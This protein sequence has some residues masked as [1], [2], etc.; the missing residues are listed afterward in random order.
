MVFQLN[1]FHSR[2]DLE[3]FPVLHT[4]HL[5][6][7]FLF[8]TVNWKTRFTFK[9]QIASALPCRCHTSLSLTAQAVRNKRR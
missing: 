5:A 6:K 1:K 3:G 7:N 8:P 2:G 4:S 9:K